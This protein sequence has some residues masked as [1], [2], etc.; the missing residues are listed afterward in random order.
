MSATSNSFVGQAT[1]GVDVVVTKD[2]LKFLVNREIMEDALRVEDFKRMAHQLKNNV[3]RRSG[4]I[5]ALKAHSSGVG[6]NEDL[7]FMERMRLEDMEKG[8]HLLLMM[9][10]TEMKIGEKIAYVSSLGDDVAEL[11]RVAGSDSMKDQ[12]V[13]LFERE[14]AESVGKIEEYRRLYDTEN[15]ARLL[16][17]ARETQRKVDE[18]NAFITRIREPVAPSPIFAELM[19]LSGERKIP[20]VSKFFLLQQIAEMR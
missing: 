2:Q 4:Y 16:S 11:A 14:V 12:L 5:G 9:K 20:R 18:K 8:T 6:S 10:E 13:M 3:R 19:D 1:R 15:A 7:K 17:L